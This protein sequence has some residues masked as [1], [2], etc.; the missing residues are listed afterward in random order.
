MSIVSDETKRLSRLV[1]AMLNMSKI[2][3]GELKLNP[4]PTAAQRPAERRTD[5]AGELRPNDHGRN[6]ERRACDAQHA[7]FQAGAA[8]I[9]PCL[10]P[11]FWIVA[12]VKCHK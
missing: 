4:K 3:A 11:N 8:R 1:T 6:G 10:E 2:E 7:A 12:G 5:P 9:K